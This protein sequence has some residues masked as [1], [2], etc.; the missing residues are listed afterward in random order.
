MSLSSVCQGTV[1][2]AVVLSSDTPF[3]ALSQT[4]VLGFLELKI[5]SAQLFCLAVRWVRNS[6]DCRCYLNQ[7]GDERNRV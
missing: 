4:C 6:G 5:S 1:Q 7:Q 2:E 3:L